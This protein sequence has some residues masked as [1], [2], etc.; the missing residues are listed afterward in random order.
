[1][2]ILVISNYSAHLQVAEGRMPNH[3][4]FGCSAMIECFLPNNEAKVKQEFGGGIIK[5]VSINK[6]SLKT[7]ISL[8]FKSFN[9]DVVYDA[10]NVVSKYF[11]VLNKY[12]LFPAKLVTIYHHPPFVKM[13]KYGKSDISLFFTENLKDLAMNNVCDGRKMIVN[14]WYPD[15]E[16][17]KINS[18][19]RSKIKIYDFLDNGKTNRDHN[20]FIKAMRGMPERKGIIVTDSKNIPSEYREG[21]NVELFLQDKPNDLTML[22]LCMKSKIMMVPLDIN[23]NDIM[24]PIGNTSYMDAIALGMPMCTNVNAA[25]AEEIKENNTGTLF[26]HNVNSMFKAM[27]LSLE[28][29]D[30]LHNNMINFAMGH[31]I[32]KYSENIIDIIFKGHSERYVDSSTIHQ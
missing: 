9:Y 21:D 3:H 30:I 24:G 10:L 6:K 4:L 11:S 29:Y 14:Q 19:S 5:F 1:M 28:N 8:Y 16:W 15:I 2:K 7:I 31:T 22:Q 18:I 20:S 13:M 32:K 26:N 25:F 27:Q 12:H 17:Y 23:D